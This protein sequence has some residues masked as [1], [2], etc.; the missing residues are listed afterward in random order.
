MP[1][2]ISLILNLILLAAVIVAISRLIKSRRNNI[3]PNHYQPSL[4]SVGN[5]SVDEIIAVRKLTEDFPEAVEE[6]E[7]F[8][9]LSL[10]ELSEELPY[11]AES[12]DN[13]ASFFNQ[14]SVTESEQTTTAENRS[15]A[16][17]QPT[18]NM[19]M[20]F[21]LAKEGRQFAGYELLQTVLAAGLRFGEGYLFHRHQQAN[22]QGPIIFS[23]AAATAS[24]IFD[25]QNIGAFS[26]RGLCLY[27]QISG[28]ST[29]D[30]DRFN[31]LYETARQLSEGLDAYL[32]D[33]QRKMLTKEGLARYQRVLGGAV[34]CEEVA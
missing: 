20:M 1:A 4:G 32:L 10:D 9:A 31:I 8:D 15:D 14:S 30:L 16:G 6:E 26:A 3:L 34:Q 27:M 24:G 19:V 22:G 25:L 13:Q 21:L 33:D 12:E 29:I 23:L 28:N 5:R 17:N 2:N 7:Q 18:S 11:E